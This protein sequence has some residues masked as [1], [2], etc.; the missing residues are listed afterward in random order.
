M[1][2]IPQPEFDLLKFFTLPRVASVIAVF[3][4]CALIIRYSTRLLDVAAQRGPRARFLVKWI[5]PLLRIGLWFLA[6]LFAFDILAPTRE[7]FFAGVGS[8]A[9]AIGLGAQDLIKNLIG[10]LVV[11]GDRPYQIGDRVR[12]GDAYGEIDHIG[13]TSTKLMTRDDTRVT[14]P[15]ASIITTQVYNSNSGV[16]D[17]QVVTDLYLPATCP[18]DRVTEIGRQAAFI[19]PFTNLAKPV[20]TLVIDEFD[21]GPYLRLRVKAYVF[22]HRY[23]LEMQSDITSRIKAELLRLNLLNWTPDELAARN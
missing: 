18:A 2:A 13:L 5:V 22:D 11:V 17:C 12:I 19:S 4:I 1:Q 10:G 15:N 23:E 21:Q 14:I 7:T 20:L 6:G 9:I 16:P 8:A 3:A